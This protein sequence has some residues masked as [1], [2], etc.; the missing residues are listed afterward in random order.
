MPTNCRG[1]EFHRWTREE[2]DYLLSNA[3]RLTAREMAA[4]LGITQAKVFAKAHGLGIDVDMRKC[5]VDPRAFGYAERFRIGWW[6]MEQPQFLNQLDKCAD[7]SARRLLLGIG[8]QG[9]TG[10]IPEPYSIDKMGR[11]RAQWDARYEVR[12]QV[13]SVRDYSPAQIERML[14]IG[15]RGLKIV[16]PEWG[17]RRAQG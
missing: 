5:N 12:K 11:R 15:S 10:H 6:N 14:V 17:E 8:E 2:T 9:D 16:R 3:R 4:H 1:K 13:A 7:D